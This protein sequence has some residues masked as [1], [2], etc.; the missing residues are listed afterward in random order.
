MI[1]GWSQLLRLIENENQFLRL[2]ID[3]GFQ[4]QRIKRRSP[5]TRRQQM[6]PL[7]LLSPGED[8]EIVTIRVHEENKTCC[9]QCNGE[10]HKKSD[11]RIEELG[12]RAGKV[13][14]MLNNGTPILL[15][16]DEARIAIDRALAMKIMVRRVQ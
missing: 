9:G 12:L 5:L 11:N 14:S 7:A 2:V 3:N 1:A 13:I 16:I 15:K 6:M 4:D 10:K 8:A